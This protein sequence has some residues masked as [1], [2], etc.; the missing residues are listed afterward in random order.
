MLFDD[1]LNKGINISKETIDN[2]KNKAIDENSNYIKTFGEL[3]KEFDMAIAI[4][5]L[6]RNNP[7]PKNSV[8]I[9]DRFGNI[10]LKY[11][12]VHTVDF[13]NEAFMEPGEEFKVCDLNYKNGIVKLGTMICFDRDFPESARVLMIKGAEIILVPNACKMTNIRLEQL[14]V[15]AY[16]NMTGIVTV[17][18]ANYGGH[19]S[20]FSPIVRDINFNDVDSELLIMDDK[21]QIK[22]VNFDMDEI[23]D[24]RKKEPLGD[25]YRKLYAYKELLNKSVNEPFV[26]DNSRR[27]YFL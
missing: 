13:K 21:E 4:T 5:F 12:K 19:S 3:A 7:L 6:E 23:M 24:Y 26:R 9:I 15:R 14:K 20:A 8:L 1:Y 10:I 27:N 22:V 11:S 17:N 2:W 25:A 18:Y 16:E